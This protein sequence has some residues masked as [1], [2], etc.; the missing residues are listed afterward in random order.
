MALVEIIGRRGV[1]A[2]LKLGHHLV[3]EAERLLLAIGFN[4]K[5]SDLDMNLDGWRISYV[6]EV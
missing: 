5:L 2:F 6:D 1:G 3:L 4:L